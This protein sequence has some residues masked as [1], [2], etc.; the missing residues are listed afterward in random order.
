MNNNVIQASVVVEFELYSQSEGRWVGSEVVAKTG[1]PGT[2]EQFKGTD[3]SGIMTF[4][5]PSEINLKMIANDLFQTAEPTKQLPSDCSAA[6]QATFAP[7]ERVAYRSLD[8][9]MA[10]SNEFRTTTDAKRQQM[11]MGALFE[12][13][14]SR[15]YPELAAYGAD[16][17]RAIYG[18]IQAVDQAQN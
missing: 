6:N 10:L 3:F 16:H 5:V 4:S 11:A 17:V 2:D 8:Q 14:F 1:V 13:G 7:M 18:L 15:F 12:Q 9:L